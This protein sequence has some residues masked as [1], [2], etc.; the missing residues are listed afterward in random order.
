MFLLKVSQGIPVQAF[1][2]NLLISLSVA[3]R[4]GAYHTSAYRLSLHINW[5][6]FRFQF[7]L[8]RLQPRLP[9]FPQICPHCPPLPAEPAPSAAALPVPCAASLFLLTFFCFTLGILFMW[10][11][12]FLFSVT[13]PSSPFLLFLPLCCSS[14]IVWLTLRDFWLTWA[15]PSSPWLPFKCRANRP[16]NQAATI[17]APAATTTTI[18][19]TTTTTTNY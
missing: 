10:L 19:S 3:Y 2:T 17:A 1:L 4:N 15:R 8:P 18:T 14:C 11:V 6:P 13:S 16:I 12:C 5:F 7:G 9:P